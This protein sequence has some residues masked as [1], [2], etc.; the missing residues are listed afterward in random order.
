MGPYLPFSAM[1]V[2]FSAF[3]S[4][5]FSAFSAVKGFLTRI[6]SYGRENQEPLTA[7]DAENGR[8]RRE[9]Q[10]VYFARWR[11]SELVQGLKLK[12]MTYFDLIA[13]Q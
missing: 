3:S 9:K 6:E 5:M 2:L 10:T 13:V 8:D 7:E 1:S 11:Q 12:L 4:L